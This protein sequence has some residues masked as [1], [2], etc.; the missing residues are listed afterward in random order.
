MKGLLRKQQPFFN[1]GSIRYAAFLE[2]HINQTGGKGTMEIICCLF[3]F[4]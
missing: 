1:T 2:N 3:F 4:R